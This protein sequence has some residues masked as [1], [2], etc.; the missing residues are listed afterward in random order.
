MLLSCGTKSKNNYKIC[1]L[2]ATS[3]TK[4]FFVI[5][6]PLFDQLMKFF[7]W[8]KN[9]VSFWRYLNFCIFVKFTDFKICD[10]II[11]MALLNNGSYCSAYFFWI[12]S[13]INTKF[14]QIL[15]C[16]KTNISNM[17]LAQCLRLE[18]SPMPFYDFIKMTIQ[19]HLNI[20]NSWH[21]PFLIVPYSPFQKKKKWNTR[22]LT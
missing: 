20:F 16:C 2:K 1:Y 13:P 10:V 4:L 3:A 19:W 7:I 9:N 22:I 18:T 11:N 12:I 15:V 5:K 14:G 17:F 8:N 6:Q 21:F